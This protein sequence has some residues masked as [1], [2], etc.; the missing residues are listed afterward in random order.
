L[1]NFPVP[2]NN[3]QDTENMNELMNRGIRH[4][5]SQKALCQPNITSTAEVYIKSLDDFVWGIG[6]DNCIP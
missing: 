4:V 3:K 5:E 6:T 2:A 1:E